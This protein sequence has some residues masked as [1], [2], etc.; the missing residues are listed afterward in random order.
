METKCS[1]NSGYT[2][3]L[4][5]NLNT[6]CYRGE[7]QNDQDTWRKQNDGL[8]SRSKES[9]RHVLPACNFEPP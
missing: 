6:L 9:T 8:F 4:Q 3:L 1:V 2:L 5:R 7:S